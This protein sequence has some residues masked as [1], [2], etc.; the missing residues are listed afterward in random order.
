MSNY[1]ID[2]HSKNVIWINPDPSRLA[3]K[4]AWFDFDPSKHEIVYATSYNPQ[5]GDTFKPEIENGYIKDFEPKKVYD[6]KTMIERVLQNWEDEIDPETETTEEPLQSKDGQNLPDQIYTPSGWKI[7]L[8]RKKESI[9]RSLPSICESK[10]VSGFFS[11]ALGAPHFYGSDREDQINLI[12][13]VSLNASVPY[14]CVDP[15]GIKEYRIHSAEQ[16]KQVLND[17]AVRKVFLLQR[18]GELKTL[19]QEANSWEE[20]SR[21]DTDT[22]WE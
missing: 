1:I 15:N 3:G 9:L 20:L 5:I 10:I 22:G 7:D 21:I 6:K 16:I 8:D 12:G 14:K 19:L 2:K 18:V 17:G 13:S 4:S 11:S